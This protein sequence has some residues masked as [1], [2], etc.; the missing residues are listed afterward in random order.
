MLGKGKEPSELLTSIINSGS[1][2]GGLEILMAY[3]INMDDEGSERM[4]EHLC[5]LCLRALMNNSYGFTSVMAHPQTIDQICLCLANVNPFRG[6]QPQD[7]IRRKYRTHILVLEL[8][9]A[10]CLVPKGHTRVLAAFDHFKMSAGESVRFQTLMH[11][12]RSERQNVSVMVAA[13]AFINVVVHC[14]ADMNFQVS[15]QHEFTLLGIMP[16][17]EDLAK[18]NFHELDEQIAA[19][20]ENFLN[21]AELVGGSL[22]NDEGVG[23]G[24]RL[25]LFLSPSS[26]LSVRSFV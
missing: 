22:G 9:A 13:M 12:L 7:L 19:Y 26:I 5:V 3:F 11:V 6:Q 24:C 8:L 14:V 25:F 23:A 18:L 10:V 17:I 16:L 2:F 4:D 1:K 21:V 20:K 15:L